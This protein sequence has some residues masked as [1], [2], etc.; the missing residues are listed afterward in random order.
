M[1]EKENISELVN[2][3]I[4]GTGLFLVDI[5]VSTG[6]DIHVFIDSPQGIE[7]EK[8][9]EISR[10][11]EELLDRE[12][13]DFSLEV[14]SPG[15]GHPFKVINQ[16]HK[17]IGRNVE[18]LFNAGQKLQGELKAVNENGI[19]VEYS[20]KEK[21]EGAK[22]PKMVIKNEEIGFDQIKSTKEIIIF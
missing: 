9:A 4:E 3:K 17:A 14:S 20:K 11:I 10:H 19:T 16:Y 21:P 13:E 22:R 15:I 1:I 6:N 7:I 18:V 8:C 2:Q 12:E 5:K